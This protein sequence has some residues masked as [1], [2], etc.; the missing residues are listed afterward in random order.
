MHFAIA[1][2]IVPLGLF[3]CLLMV[4]ASACVPSAALDSSAPAPEPESESESE[5]ES[6]P[7]PSPAHYARAPEG[8]QLH[9]DPNPE[10][11]SVQLQPDATRPIAHVVELLERD[12]TGEWWRVRTLLPRELLA[13]GLHSEA[14]VA[15]M[16]LEGWVLAQQLVEFEPSAAASGVDRNSASTAASRPAAVSPAPSMNIAVRLVI[17]AGTVVRW[18]DGRPAGEVAQDHGFY[19]PGYTPGVIGEHA[20]QRQLVCFDRRSG[21]SVGVI[22]GTLCTTE[23]EVPELSFSDS[24]LLILNMPTPFAADDPDAPTGA[25]DR[26]VIRRIVRAHLDDVRDCYNAGLL[27]DPDLEGRVAINFMISKD[28]SVSSALVSEDTLDDPTVGQCIAKAVE[29]WVFPAPKGGGNV[30]VTYP[31]NLTPG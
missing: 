7:A 23:A 31:F 4:P 14:G 2:R 10:A 25:L 12:T 13:L 5:S 11:S 28:G 30:I 3:G 22:D 15:L 21:P 20:E 8:L 17:R 29:G 26:D 16:V 27:K 1:A 18:P 9:A 6:E 19:T 24:T